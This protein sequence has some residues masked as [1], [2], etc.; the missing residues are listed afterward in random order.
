MVEGWRWNAGCGCCDYNRTI[1]GIVKWWSGGPLTATQTKPWVIKF[2]SSGTVLW[3][4]D[5]VF[6]GGIYATDDSGSTYAGSTRLDSTT[7]VG[8]AGIFPAKG[9]LL[10]H[11]N[12]PAFTGGG[13]WGSAFQPKH[14]GPG[15][16]TLTTATAP[17]Y[18]GQSTSL[19]SN[20]NYEYR[21]NVTNIGGGM[22]DAS[23][24]KKYNLANYPS[25][26]SVSEADAWLSDSGDLYTVG[27]SS[28][29]PGQSEGYAFKYRAADGTIA[30]AATIGGC[31]STITGD[32]NG[33]IYVA[34]G[35][36]SVSDASTLLQLDESTGAVNWG[37]SKGVGVP[38]GISDIVANANGVYC[39]GH[40]DA[41]G[42]NVHAVSPGG[43][44]MWANSNHPHNPFGA[45]VA[46]FRVWLD[47]SDNI[48]AA[49]GQI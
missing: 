16:D 27:E 24:N 7:G 17:A 29:R 43:S 10:A 41:T 25:G 42:N 11:P 40:A 18:S 23:G 1:S 38:G 48:Y 21:L 2:D 34:G 3:Q 13:T 33:N 35:N 45:S 19:T 32:D 5:P 14:I 28:V 20:A 39:A 6:L 4:S 26:K 47:G 22:F 44:L 9:R 49:G 46:T 31:F 37:W 12:L 8:V 30:W 15:S 36:R